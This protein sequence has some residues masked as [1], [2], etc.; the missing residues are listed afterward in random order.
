[1]RIAAWWKTTS[2]PRISRVDERGIADVA[3]DDPNRAA[4]PAPR[5]VL[6]TAPDEVVEDDDLRRAGI[7]QQVDDVRADRAGPSG[8]KGALTAQRKG[9]HA[10]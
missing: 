3:L 4:R 2:T 9:T 10:Q 8:H 1:M 7:H 6:P 5:Q